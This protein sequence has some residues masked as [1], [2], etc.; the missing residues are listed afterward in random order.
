MKLRVTL[1]VQREVEIPFDGINTDGAKIIQAVEYATLE[2]PLLFINDRSA[3]ITV[4]AIQ[5]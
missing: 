2:D 5:I 3:K 4:E 1:T